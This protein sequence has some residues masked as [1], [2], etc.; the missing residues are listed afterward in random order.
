MIEISVEADIR[1]AIRYLDDA[2]LRRVPIATQRALLKTAQ[3]VKAAEIAEMG[4]VFDRPTRWTLGAMKVGPTKD[5]T[6]RVGVLDPDGYYKRANFYLGTQIYGGARKVKA[7]ERALQRA[8]VMPAGWF[9]VPGEKAKMDAYGNQSVGEI[10]QIL[11]W[12]NA[13]EP[14][15]GSTQN[16]TDQTRAKRRKGS[17]KKRGFE[18]FAI[19]PFR[20]GSE[21]LRPGIYRRTA[22]AFGKAIEP[23][24]IFVEKT[25]YKKRFNFIRVA[26]SVK[27]KVFAQYFSDA[28]ERDVAAR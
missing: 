21:G 3:A 20:R 5:F 13:A 4:R 22:F 24:V 11:S 18:Y 23:V 10:K 8:G 14:Y 1:S 28:L 16:M 17:R 25:R 6:V 19:M 12:F 15:A 9:A 2:Q 27:E 7:F 26:E